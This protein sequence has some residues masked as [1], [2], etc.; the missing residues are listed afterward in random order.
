MFGYGNDV[1]GWE[2]G[3]VVLFVRFLHRH[4]YCPH[5]D[6]NDYIETPGNKNKRFNRCVISALRYVE[7]FLQQ[8]GKHSF[9]GTQN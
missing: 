9:P 2:R 3:G 5:N 6:Y 1:V 4:E 7:Q 8:F